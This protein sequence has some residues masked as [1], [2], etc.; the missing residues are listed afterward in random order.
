MQQFGTAG[1]EVV[2]RHSF[3]LVLLTDIHCRLRPYKTGHYPTDCLSVE[4][5][6]PP[7]NYYYYYYKCHDLSD[8][9]TTVAGGTLQSLPIKML[10]DSCLNDGILSVS[11][12]NGARFLSAK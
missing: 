6:P 5:R 8:A 1:V 2:S 10:R 11:S 9:I 4:G 12:L 7:A 3:I